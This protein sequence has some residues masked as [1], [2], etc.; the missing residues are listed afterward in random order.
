[1]TQPPIAPTPPEVSQGFRNRQPNTEPG[2]FW[3]ALLGGSAAVHLLGVVVAFPLMARLSPRQQAI[4]STSIEFIELPSA[5]P[6]KPPAIAPTAEA[7][8]ASTPPKAIS[9]QVIPEQAIPEQAI[10]I[11]PMVP[12][13]VAPAVPAPP[14]P[15]SQQPNPPPEA[16]TL[17]G[18]QNIPPNVQPALP[19]QTSQQV[20]SSVPSSQPG[21]TSGPQIGLTRID[22]PPPD[23]SEVLTLPSDRPP[24]QSVGNLAPPDPQNTQLDQVGAQQKAE[25]VKLV[26]SLQVAAVPPEEAETPLPDV[27]AQPKNTV[28]G[29]SS[30]TFAADPTISPCVPDAEA[31]ESI[32][33]GASV[34][35]Q[36]STDAQGQVLD[37]ALRQSSQN[38]GYDRLAI[39]LVKNWEYEPAIAQGQPVPSKALIVRA[40]INRV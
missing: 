26:A 11:A 34:D 16:S 20:A 18:T 13:P 30:Y 9:E 37:T 4:E 12:A 14:Q 7:P 35:L 39:C 21:A 3:L 17:P 10:A 33:S 27:I 5:A 6:A 2:W 22:R 40:T 24:A 23:V 15:E 29:I 32:G 38:P 8:P 25:P 1:M 36:V 19:D 28:D 31:A